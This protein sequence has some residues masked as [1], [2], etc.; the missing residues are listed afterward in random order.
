MDNN[1]LIKKFR[2]SANVG[3][4]GSIAVILIAVKL[5]HVEFC[6]LRAADHIIFGLIN[7]N[8]YSLCACRHE[9]PE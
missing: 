4:Y 2:H 7:E 5:D 8:A 1:T 6:S 9:L 3:L